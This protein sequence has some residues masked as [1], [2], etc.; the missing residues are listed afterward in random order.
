MRIHRIL[1]PIDLSDCSLD[2]LEIAETLA[3]QNQAEVLLLCVEEAIIP[4]DEK[5]ETLLDPLSLEDHGRLAH[6]RAR[7]TH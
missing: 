3:R 4:Y 7:P 6:I 1:V 2:A 5:E